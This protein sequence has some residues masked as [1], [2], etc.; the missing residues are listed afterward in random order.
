MIL[1]TGATGFLGTYLIDT[2]LTAGYEIRVLVRDAE[3]RQLPP[4]SKLVE[5]V[6]GDI[7]DALVLRKALEGIDLVIHAA[8]MVSF[9]RGDTPALLNINVRGTETLIDACLEVEQPRIIHVSSIASIGRTTDNSLADEETPWLA[10]QAQSGYALSKYKAEREVYRG[11]AEGLEAVIVNPGV[12]LGS[13]DWNQGTPQL[14]AR[15]ADGLRFCPQG[16]NGW[17]GAKD[18]ASAC[19]FLMEHPAPNGSR[20]ILVGEND[21]YQNV[22]GR[23]A[24]AL[25]VKGPQ[26]TLPRWVLVGAAILVER[27]SQWLRKPAQLT[28]AAMRSA[29]GFQAYDGTKITQMGFEYTPIPQLIQQVADRY[30]QDHAEQS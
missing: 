4:W 3:N 13:G 18:V 2:L 1:L 15:V 5:V 20:F 12:I 16:V 11:I 27:V 10:Q 8:A 19:R 30:L 14:F 23:M 26:Q 6:S 7:L 29:T 17:V 28:A 24:E 21:S 9:S 22:F 25:G